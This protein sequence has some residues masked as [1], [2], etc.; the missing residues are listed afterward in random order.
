MTCMSGNM[1]LNLLEVLEKPFQLCALI[2]VCQHII[3]FIIRYQSFPCFR[4]HDAGFGDTDTVI[5]VSLKP[6]AKRVIFT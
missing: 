1:Q 5:H 4:S 6:I 3:Q 2:M